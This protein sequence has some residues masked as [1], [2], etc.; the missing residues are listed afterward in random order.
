MNVSIATKPIMINTTLDS[1]P[2]TSCAN[3]F[4]SRIMSIATSYQ[5]EPLV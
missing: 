2:F 3:V 5:V 1:K 4:M